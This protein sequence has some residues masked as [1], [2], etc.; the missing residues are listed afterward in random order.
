[1]K[2]LVVSTS[3]PIHKGSTSGVFVKRLV[4][5]LSKSVTLHVVVPDGRRQTEIDSGYPVYSFR[6]APK[7]MQTLSHEPGGLPVAMKSSPLRIAFL[8]F[9]LLAFCLAIWRKSDGMDVIHANWSL[10]GLI[11][12]FV[13]KLKGIPVFTT[14]RG[15][16]A[17][18]LDRSWLK[19]LILKLLAKWNSKLITVSGAMS[20]ELSRRLGSLGP[21]LCHIPN[22]VG[23]KFLEVSTVPEHTDPLKLLYVGSLIPRKQVDTA[24]AALSIARGHTTLTIVGDGPERHRLVRKAEELGLVKRVVFLG[25]LPESEIPN[26]LSRHHALLLCSQSE[27]RPNVVIEAMASGRVVLATA[28]PGVVEILT[29]DQNGLLFNIGDAQALAE[30]I[31]ELERDPSLKVRLGGAAKK[32]ILDNRLTWDRCAQSY[33]ELFA[34]NNKLGQG[35]T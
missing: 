23:D 13:G 21:L 27:G 9:Y 6:Y 4:D 3:F 16:D 7:S 25:E 18:N 14:L 5:E 1:M 8:P 33:I 19:R 26:I 30:M 28:L 15:D 17:A 11:A 10:P 2:V 32:Y 31:K 20:R 34:L 22:G 29:H 24:I 12:G 35:K